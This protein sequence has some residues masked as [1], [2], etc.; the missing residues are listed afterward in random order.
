M[1]T[2]GRRGKSFKCDKKD[3]KSLEV[4]ERCRNLD[5]NTEDMGETILCFWDKEQV[6][7]T[8]RNGRSAPHCNLKP[9]G[10]RKQS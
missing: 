3:N 4:R 6:E 1:I 7:F 10:E 2:K 5:I 9:K 8:D